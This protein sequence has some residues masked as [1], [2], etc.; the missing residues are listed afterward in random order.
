MERKQRWVIRKRFK[1]LSVYGWPGVTTEFSRSVHEAITM[2]KR[3]ALSLS[4][5]LQKEYYPEI[6]AAIYMMDDDDHNMPRMRDYLCY[7]GCSDD[8]HGGD[9]TRG[10][11]PILSYEEWMEA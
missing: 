1:Y 9:I 8:G 4:A 3:T 2:D 5:Q 11:L 7:V 6:V 10:G